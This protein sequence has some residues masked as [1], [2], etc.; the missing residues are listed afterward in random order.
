[1]ANKF[2]KFLLFTAAVGTAAAA[3]YYY[4][5]KKENEAPFDED[6][7]DYDNFFSDDVRESS[8]ASR[9][10]VPLNSGAAQTEHFSE[11]ISE[12][13]EKVSEVAANVKD[14]F[15]PLAEKA[16]SAV[17]TVQNKIEETME[18]F[19]D[20]GDSDD[21]PAPME[22]RTEETAEPLFDDDADLA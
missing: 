18:D 15:T 16:V 10:Y 6:D 17:Q 14:T 22:T 11:K 4:T 21:E 2:G 1:M 19:F 12:V 5:Q 9:N 8:D 13:S 3:V 7:D 20:E